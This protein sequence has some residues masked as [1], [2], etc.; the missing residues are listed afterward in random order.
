MTN[1]IVGNTV[2]TYFKLNLTSPGTILV[3]LK[4]LL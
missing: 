1:V 2:T 3:Y 4:F